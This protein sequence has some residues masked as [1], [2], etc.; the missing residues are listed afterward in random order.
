VNPIREM[1]ECHKQRYLDTT[2]S[3]KRSASFLTLPNKTPSNG[4]AEHH[5]MNNPAIGLIRLKK[6]AAP[7]MATTVICALSLMKEVVPSLRPFSRPVDFCDF[8]LHAPEISPADR[9]ASNQQP[10]WERNVET[11][12]VLALTPGH[13]ANQARRPS[14]RAKACLVFVM[15]P[16][17]WRNQD[18]IAMTSDNVHGMDAG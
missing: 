12:T 3:Q 17:L 1:L 2:F 13:Q 18:G 10:G 7:T 8:D 9:A 5:K 14:L 4:V 11:V 15:G 6:A 16:G